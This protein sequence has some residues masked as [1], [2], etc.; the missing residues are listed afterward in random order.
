MATKKIVTHTVGSMP[1]EPSQNDIV[2][3]AAMISSGR[4]TSHNRA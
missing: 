3:E 2:I 4:E 1:R